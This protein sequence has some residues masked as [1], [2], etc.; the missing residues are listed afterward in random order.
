MSA[1][2]RR[3]SETV[4]TFAKNNAKIKMISFG[5]V[6]GSIKRL[7]VLGVMSFFFFSN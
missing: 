5:A 3:E 1:A 7:I 2:S 6:L 4:P